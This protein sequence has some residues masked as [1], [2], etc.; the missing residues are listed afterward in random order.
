MRQYRKRSDDQL[1][2]S[3]AA[4]DVERQ[5]T[6]V[7]IR[8]RIVDGPE[9]GLYTRP[10]GGRWDKRLGRYVGIWSPEAE[11]GAGGWVGEQPKRI[12]VVRVAQQ[13]IGFIQDFE[14]A[15]AMALGGRRSGK[16]TGSLAPKILVLLL[17]MAGLPGEVLSPTYR[18]SRNVWRAVLKLSPRAWWA[19]LHKTEHTMELVNGSRVQLL[20]ADNDNSARSEGVAW[21]AKDET[22]D[23]SED[24]SANALLS[25]SEAGQ[26]PFICETATI[27]PSLR[28]HYDKLMAS[29]NARVYLM[30]SRGNPFID[31]AIF[32]LAEEFLDKA[33]IQRE[34]EAQWP[35]LVGRVYYPF[36]EERHVRTA[37]ALDAR[38]AEEMDITALFCAEKF[39][40]AASGPMSC[41][42]LIGV[43][44]PHHA[45]IAKLHPDGLLHVVDEIVIGADGRPGDVRDLAKACRARC[46]SS[47]AIVVRDP[48]E[49]HWDADVVKYFK[50]ARFRVTMMRRVD[51]EMRLTAMRARLERDKLLIA[52][53]CR[54]LIEALALQTYVGGK[55]DKVTKSKITTTMSM[56][57][58][59]DALGYLVY[60][61]WPPLRTADF[62][63]L[64]EQ[65]AA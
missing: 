30:R 48:H 32:D 54:H 65:V 4:R 46:G 31:H 6:D 23:I 52:P 16:T 13:S 24:A 41:E 25:A 40:S 12:H 34:L 49:T 44:P 58:I 3:A 57:H 2:R 18:Q 9:A 37:P 11:D 50:Q 29:A 45:A 33:T 43:D 10:Y 42:Y 17:C 55:P 39:D 28:A 15:I 1:A 63:R 62:E 36:V 22:Q 47:S 26:R 59:A 38:G 27:K 61:L 20:S 53:T 56:D 14:S 7:A 51:I 35:D 8:F 64:E 60:R 21:V 5:R 19:S